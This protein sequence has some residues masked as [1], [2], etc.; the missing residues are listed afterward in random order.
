[1]IMQHMDQPGRAGDEIH[2]MKIAVSSQTPAVV[3]HGLERP[4]PLPIEQ[5]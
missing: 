1:M 5:G 4:V 3:Q 2:R